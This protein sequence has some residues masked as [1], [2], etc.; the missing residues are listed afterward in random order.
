MIDRRKIVHVQLLPLMSGVQKVSLDEISR[1]DRGRYEP[2]VVCKSDGEFTEKLRSMNVRVHLVPELE[3]DLRPV[4]DI[5]AFVRMY[6]FFKKEKPSI[7]HTHSSKTG[8]LGRL[9]AWC[10]GIPLIIHT[11]HGFAFPAESRMPVRTVF[12]LLERVCG[13]ITDRMIVLNDSDATIARELLG[14]P[15]SRQALLPN[16]VDIDTYAPAAPPLRQALRQGIFGVADE[17]RVTIGMVGRLWL[18]KN[19]QCFVRAAMRV[20]EQRTNVGFYLVGDGEFRSEVEATI[21]ACGHAD[22]IAILGWRGDVPDILKALDIMVL[23]SRWEG[24]PLAI[25]EAMSSAVTVVASDIPGNNHIVRDGVDGCLFPADDSDA[26]ASVLIDLIDH[27]QTRA[28]LSACGRE[29]IVASYTLS[30]RM[31]KITSIYEAVSP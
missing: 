4:R 19:P 17:R 12:R 30:Q 18:Q 20:L 24:M 16:G 14:V 9:A 25:L 26:L 11:V 3:R 23:P 28:R 31:S 2:I 1:L 21:Q 8:V 5:Q 10:A 7:V 22:A 6:S 29:K 13:Q 15:N 27:P